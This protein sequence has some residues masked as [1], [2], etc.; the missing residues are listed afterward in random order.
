M[1]HPVSNKDRLSPDQT[2]KLKRAGYHIHQTRHLRRA[3]RLIDTVEQRLRAPYPLLLLQVKGAMAYAKREY[4]PALKLFRE[5]WERDKTH[6]VAYRYLGQLYE[7]INEY[8]IALTF[9]RQGLRQA[10]DDETLQVH[11]IQALLQDERY[12]TAQTY[13]AQYQ[14]N[15]PDN[16]HFLQLAGEVHRRDGK[17]PEAVTYY[18]QGLEKLM[19]LPFPR[20]ASQAD[21]ESTF[22]V[23]RHEDTLWE[24]LAQLKAA[25]IEAFPAFGTLLGLTRDGQL[26]PFDKDVDLG[27]PHTQVE[28][29]LA[30]LEEHGWKEVGNSFGMSNPR[31]ISNPKKGLAIDL[32]AFY[33]V[34]QHQVAVGGFVMPNIP[35]KWNYML[36]FPRVQLKATQRPHGEVWEPENAEAIVE[37]I[38]GEGWRY[39]DPYFATF[40]GEPNL[41]GFSWLTQCYAYIRLYKYWGK[42]S[43]RKMDALLYHMLRHQPE[44]ELLEN[45]QRVVKGHLARET[46]RQEHDD[47]MDEKESATVH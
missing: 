35:W 16:P 31:A 3:Q 10:P 27:L 45:A 20:D 28:T 36:R 23:E 22:A 24:V 15:A 38:Y 4:F 13:L 7:K 17:L 39:P 12:D 29:A 5:I 41:M 47:L 1:S 42:G 34:P 14:Q 33:D 18:R 40:G 9:Y 37:A 30:C 46:E 6:R 2:R 11:Y 8:D 43:F 25:G 32:C 26:L 21:A 44:D 19:E